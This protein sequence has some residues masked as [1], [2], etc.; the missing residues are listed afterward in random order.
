[1]GKITGYKL[2]EVIGKN[3]RILKSEVHDKDFYKQMWDDILEKGS[4]TGEVTNKN[5]EG[6]Y[7]QELLTIN[8]IEDNS[9]N[10]I[11]HIGVFNDITIQ[12]EQEK[13]LL[14]Q[15]RTSAVGEMIGNI[16]HQWRQPLSVISTVS[17]GIRL[18]MQLD[19]KVENELLD[20]KLTMI[21]NQTKYLSKTIDDFRN[22]FRGDQK[23]IEEVLLIDTIKAATLTKDS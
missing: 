14:Q 20:E 1:M 18:H 2:Q 11:N 12:K 7:F 21:V 22:F 13:I 23:E 4:W 19:G 5:K 3:P 17:S 15:S 16:A 10:I 8:K 6:D 9:G